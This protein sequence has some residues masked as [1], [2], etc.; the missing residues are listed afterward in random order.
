MTKLDPMILTFVGR[1]STGTSSQTCRASKPSISFL[2]LSS[3]SV[4]FPRGSL[5][6]NNSVIMAV[7]SCALCDVVLTDEE[8]DSD[9]D[10][11]VE[12]CGGVI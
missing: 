11:R 5:I 2:F 7:V 8:P 9:V 3:N 1:D 6:G 4:E 10:G 12:F